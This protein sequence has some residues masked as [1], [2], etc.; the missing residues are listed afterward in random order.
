MVGEERGPRALD[1]QGLGDGVPRM[2]DGEEA[3]ELVWDLGS[4]TELRKGALQ[5]PR[6]QLSE[7]LALLRRQ[8]ELELPTTVGADPPLRARAHQ[9]C[10]IVAQRPW[11]CRRVTSP[12]AFSREPLETT[13]LPLWWTSSISLVAFSSE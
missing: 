3:P 2:R 8:A 4:L 6:R 5:T 13:A 10:S 11:L 7:Q 1:V 9:D 12:S